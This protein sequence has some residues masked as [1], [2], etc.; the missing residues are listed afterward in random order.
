[1]EFWLLRYK[2]WSQAKVWGLLFQERN[3]LVKKYTWEEIPAVPELLLLPVQDSSVGQLV[4]SVN[5]RYFSA[6]DAGAQAGAEQGA[7][8]WI[9]LSFLSIP[10]WRVSPLHEW[11]EMSLLIWLS[12]TDTLDALSLMT[13]RSSLI[14]I[15]VSPRFSLT[16][17][18]AN[19]SCDCHGTS[20]K[21]PGLRKTSL[22]E[23]VWGRNATFFYIS[24][25]WARYS[26][27]HQSGK[28]AAVRVEVSLGDSFVR[29]YISD[30]ELMKERHRR[31]SK[32]CFWQKY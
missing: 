4:T 32:W 30:H 26:Y 11:L 22:T 21:C 14:L 25:H 2:S 3:D 18:N 19:W 28:E 15:S 6:E 7:G 12:S 29:N 10:A 9:L 5:H 13:Q 17:Q 1:M 24:F 31:N 20:L 27:R 8:R 23:E 16:T